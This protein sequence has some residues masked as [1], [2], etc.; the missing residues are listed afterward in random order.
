MTRKFHLSIDS[1]EEF[2]L[3]CALI[4]GEPLEGDKL[5][6]LADKLHESS[7]ALAAAEAAD[8]K[9]RPRS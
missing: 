4:R 8:K 7:S 6:A 3:F 2:A 1:V 9:N 5:K